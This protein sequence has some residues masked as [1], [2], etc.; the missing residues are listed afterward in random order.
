MIG[1]IQAI[2]PANHSGISA[3]HAAHSIRLMSGDDIP[4]LMTIQAECYPPHM[5]ESE[6]VFRSRL[7]AAPSTCWVLTEHQDQDQRP[8]AYLF[9]YPSSKGAITALDAPF[10]IASTPD[11]LYLHD[12]AVAPHM[13]GKK[14]ANALV[15]AALKRAREDG[16]GWSALV[17]VQHSQPFWMAQGYVPVEIQHSPAREN[18]DSYQA[19]ANHGPAIYMLQR[20]I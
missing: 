7:D 17:S 3:T 8:A 2:S 12:L 1:Q 16:L 4:V 14:A 6:A 9:S 18:L 10:K 15:S 20:L 11:C 13:R 19:S 5:L